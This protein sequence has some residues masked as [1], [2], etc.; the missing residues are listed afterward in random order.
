MLSGPSTTW[1]I[2]FFVIILEDIDINMFIFNLYFSYSATATL[3]TL[4]SI[5]ISQRKERIAVISSIYPK[6]H[7]R[8]IV[9][10][11]FFKIT[12]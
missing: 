5:C 3:H 6:L 7:T 8:I 4:F 2:N 11:F 1:N 9:P 12:L 10:T